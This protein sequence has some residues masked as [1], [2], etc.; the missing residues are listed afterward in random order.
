MGV[1]KLQFQSY[2]VIGDEQ[3]I[4][5]TLRMSQDELC[6][7]KYEMLVQSQRDHQR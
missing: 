4:L 5:N 1:L 2:K 3:F 6:S 7:K